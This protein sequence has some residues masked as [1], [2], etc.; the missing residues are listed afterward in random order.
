MTTRN[1]LR[2]SEARKRL[3]QLVERVAQGGA[4]VAIG[5]YG[6]E[7]AILVSAE[8]YGRL[9]TPPKRV[10]RT[11]AGTLTLAC[12]PHELISESRRLGDLWLAAFENRRQTRRSRRRSR[13]R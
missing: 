5:R 1:P 2:I 11:L 4:P 6:R 12:S 13:T 9:K 3:S 10:D 8:E 7:R